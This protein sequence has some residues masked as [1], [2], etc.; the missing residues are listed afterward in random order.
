MGAEDFAYFAE[1][2]PGLHMRLGVRNEAAGITA[3]GHS[4]E[5]RLDEAA[6]ESG[7]QALVGFVFAVNHNS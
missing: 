6:L 1:R 2:A 3:S 5:F 4:P 7:V